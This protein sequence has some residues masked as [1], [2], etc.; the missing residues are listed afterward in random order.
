MILITIP[1]LVI[2][3]FFLI[4]AKRYFKIEVNNR[5]IIKK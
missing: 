1:S 5:K 2:I 3:F 4:R